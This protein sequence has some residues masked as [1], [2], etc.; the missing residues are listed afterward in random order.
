MEC[1]TPLR[2][3]ANL[4]TMFVRETANLLDRF[5]LAKEAGFSAVELAFPYDHPKEDVA[6]AL[7]RAGLHQVLINADPGTTLGLAAL[8]GRE[9]DFRHSLE[10]SVEYCQALK[11]PRYLLVRPEEPGSS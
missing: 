10:T 11:C 6:R 7:N 9:A 2:Y 5:G 4:S 3:C 1:P 8:P